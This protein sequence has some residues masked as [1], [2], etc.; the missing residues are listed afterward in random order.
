KVSDADH[1]ADG[2]LISEEMLA[3]RLSEDAD[4][5]FRGFVVLLPRIAAREAP[6]VQREEGLVRSENARRRVA[7]AVDDER[8]RSDLGMIGSDAHRF[9]EDRATVFFGHA[10]LPFRARA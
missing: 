5:R 10:A 2:I 4:F 6:I 1:P 7:V 3:H 8:A 9:A